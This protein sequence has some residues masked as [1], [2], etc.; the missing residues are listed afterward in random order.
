LTNVL[1]PKRLGLL[2]ELVPSAAVIAILLN[3]T[4]STI[5]AQTKLIH[6]AARAI[7][8]KIHILH[9]N[10]EPEFDTALGTMAQL[11]AGALLVGADPFFNSQR[12]TLVGLAARHAVPAIYEQREFV[13][14]GGFASYG[15]SLTHAYRQV[16][17]YTGKV[18]KGE[19]P[20]DLPVVQSAEFEFVI[21]LKAAKA[22]GLTISRDVLLIA[23]EVIE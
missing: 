21:N 22:L 1:N 23:D 18:L 4:N 10:T 8:Q 20:A 19:K 16:G 3:P 9:A 5:Q 15:T 7:G 11:G 14:A 13:V 6:D 2:R 12:A 17:I